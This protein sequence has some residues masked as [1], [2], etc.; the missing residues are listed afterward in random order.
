MR[1]LAP[2]LSPQIVLVGFSMATDLQ[3]LI[4]PRLGG[5]VYGHPWGRVYFDL[6][7]AGNLLE[8]RD[9]VGKDVPPRTEGTT[10][11]RFVRA[12]NSHLA[13]SRRFKR[14]KLAMSLVT[15]LSGRGLS[16]WQG[17]ETAVDKVLDEQSGYR[18]RLAEALIEQIGR[19]A[20]AA[21]R[22]VVLVNIPYLAQA[23]DEVWEASFG[24]RPE[25]YDRF[26]GVRR[27]E[28]ICRKADIGFVDTTMA[29]V[30]EV[31]RTGTWL[32][33]RDD[34]HPTPEGQR[35]IAGVVACHLRESGAIRVRSD[36]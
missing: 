32:H 15:R 24:T 7:E 18:W 1:D 16:L 11:G 30:D 23:Y 29:F 9:L 6:D 22:S 10:W 8:L 27:L 31:R 35:L 20:H 4:P 17:T 19:E 14:S 5:F 36:G 12:L 13:L 21:G 25:R 28:E 33:F 34:A 3:D 26:V 2:T